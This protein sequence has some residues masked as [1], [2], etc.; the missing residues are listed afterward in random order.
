MSALSATG[1]GRGTRWS[2]LSWKRIG[3]ALRKPPRRLLVVLVGCAGVAGAVILAPALAR[4]PHELS[5]IGHGDPRWLLFALALEALSFGGQVV[6]F[7]AVYQG[8]GARIGYR[9]SY[10]ITLAGHAATRLLASA[11]TG[12]MALT[13]WAVRR[14]GL[15]LRDVARR[16]VAFLVL[17]YSVYTLALL[18]G[19]IGLATGALSGGGSP[20]LTL[21]PAATAASRAA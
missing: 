10:E 6:L 2:G 20:A 17:M 4:L 16:M 21:V 9:D 12:G 18:V 8:S 7:H 14:H 13:A 3:R 15:G 5:R 19:G 11:G 1:I